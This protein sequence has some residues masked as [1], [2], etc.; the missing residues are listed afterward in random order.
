MS[1]GRATR[2]LASSGANSGGSEADRIRQ[3]SL[4]RVREFEAALN[5]VF[6]DLRETDGDL[7]LKLLPRKPA[8]CAQP[9]RCLVR[10]N[11]AFGGFTVML[12]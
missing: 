5:F 1:C 12:L 6:L 3:L 10:I 7:P 4:F 2:R 11:F 9:Y 8:S